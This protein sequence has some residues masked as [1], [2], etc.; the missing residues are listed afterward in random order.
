MDIHSLLDD[1]AAAVGQLRQLL[2]QQQV[3]NLES[4]LVSMQLAV[5]KLNGY[6]GGV[7][8]LRAAIETLPE[9]ARQEAL[10][11]LQRLR[12]DYDINAELIRLA[13][14][15]NAAVQAYAAQTSAAATYSSEGGVSMSNPGSLLGKF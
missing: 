15:R 4:A 13:M 11:R 14:Q 1:V 12:Q 7:A 5:D 6:P 9:P 3:Q 10:T 2:E 8:G